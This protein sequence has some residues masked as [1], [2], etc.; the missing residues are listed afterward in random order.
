MLSSPLRVC[1]C[2]VLPKLLLHQRPSGSPRTES[3][4]D[5]IKKTGRG[6]AIWELLSCPPRPFLSFHEQASVSLPFAGDREL[7]QG[8]S[9][10]SSAHSHQ[11]TSAAWWYLLLASPGA[12][13]PLLFFSPYTSVVLVEYFATYPPSAP[14]CLV[15]YL[16]FIF[17]ANT[18]TS[19]FPP[20]TFWFFF[21]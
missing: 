16:F 10:S 15:L 2:S 9:S 13:L 17:F 20:P 19:T 3:F 11:V 1:F 6:A 12:H 21:L 5:L 4:F 7:S 18:P 8:S 14:Y